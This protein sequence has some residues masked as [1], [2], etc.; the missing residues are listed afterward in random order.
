MY[1]ATEVRADQE[2]HADN[3]LITTK[4]LALANTLVKAWPELFSPATTGTLIES[5]WNS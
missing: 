3:T 4:E 2:F 1:F 5:S